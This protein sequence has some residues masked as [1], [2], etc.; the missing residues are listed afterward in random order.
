MKPLNKR[1]I[2]LRAKKTSETSNKSSIR[3][4][5]F[6]SSIDSDFFRIK[7]SSKPVGN[8][9]PFGPPE[10]CMICWK[11]LDTHG[12]GAKAYMECRHCG[13]KAHQ[14]HMLRWLAKK[15]FCPYCQGKW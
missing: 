12:I 9:N 11:S 7:L 2:Q 1:N 6:T 15:D 14:D 4:P 5:R 8:W 10:K 3:F 13:R